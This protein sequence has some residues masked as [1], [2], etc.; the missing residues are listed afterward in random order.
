MNPETFHSRPVGRQSVPDIVRDTRIY[1]DVS[2]SR[3]RLMRSAWVC[4]VHPKVTETVGC[5]VEEKMAKKLRF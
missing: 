2:E 4:S 1:R 3:E 5:L